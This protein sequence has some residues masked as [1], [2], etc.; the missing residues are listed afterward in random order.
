MP[1]FKNLYLKNETMN[2]IIFL[3]NSL[4]KKKKY[5]P[6]DSEKMLKK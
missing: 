4:I 5:M 1:E 6:H 2:K 3:Q